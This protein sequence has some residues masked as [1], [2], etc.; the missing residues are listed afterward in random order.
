MG[1]IASKSQSFLSALASPFLL[2]PAIGYFLVQSTWRKIHEMGLV[3]TNKGPIPVVSVGNIA[4]GG[5][6]KTPFVIYLVEQLAN[7]GL[8]PCVVSR[9]YKG[10]YTEEA[11]V[12]GDWTSQAPKFSAG[13]VGDEPF[14]MA[15]ALAGK[16]PIIV[17]RDRL[18]CVEFAAENLACDVAVLDDGFQH[19]RLGRDVDIVLLSGREDH[20]FPLGV[21]REPISALSRSHFLI[22]SES[23]EVYSRKVRSLSTSLKLYKF[24]SFP[25][26]LS[27]DNHG[28]SMASEYLKGRETLLVSAIA[29]PQ[30]FRKMTENLEWKITNHLIYRDHHIYD[31]KDLTRV[32]KEAKGAYIVFTEKDWVKL[33]REFQQREEVY[34]LRIG[35]ELRESELFMK[36]LMELLNINGSQS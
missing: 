12:V 19:L 9:G 24:R 8:K 27:N 6:G 25:V 14:L 1:R 16:S 23:E 32:V 4:L 10:A 5:T 34:F 18:R 30:R 28:K 3:D 7:R 33:P 29:N 2:A 26:C 21:L 35:I 17:G 31:S 11:L 36:Q 13:Y 15:K 22:I 20:M